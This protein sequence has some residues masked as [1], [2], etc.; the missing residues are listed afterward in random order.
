MGRDGDRVRE[1]EWGRERKLR[2]RQVDKD[3]K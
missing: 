1:T 2:E 3:R